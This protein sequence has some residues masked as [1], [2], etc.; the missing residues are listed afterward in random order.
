M[1][2]T[3]I[4]A[5]RFMIIRPNRIE[6]GAAMHV[7]SAIGDAFPLF[8]VVLILLLIVTVSYIKYEKLHPLAVIAFTISVISIFLALT[9]IGAQNHLAGMGSSARASLGYGFW[10]LLAGFILILVEH[11][12]LYV[13][14][15]GQSNRLPKH[16]IKSLVLLLCMTMLIVLYALGLLSGISIVRELTDKSDRIFG[17]LIRHMQLTIGATGTGLFISLFLSYIAYRKPVVERYVNMIANFAQVVPT[18]ALLGF[19]MIPLSILS[20]RYVF[21]KEIGISGIGFFPAYIVLTLYTLLPITTNTLAGFKT[22]STSVL[23][24]AQGM[25]MNRRQML[26]KIELP[27]AFPAIYT[28]TKTALIQAVG[29]CIL[30]GLVGGG[31]LGAILFLGLAQSA[32]DLV[33]VASLTVVLIAVFLDIVL[34]GF[35]GIIN[36]R[37]REEIEYD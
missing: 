19:I 14:K 28:G 10:M 6:S 29:N 18:L 2:F 36:K 16:L 22:I 21:L 34:T 37:F 35:E 26:L 15:A 33:I 4:A 7:G 31:G 25:G 11:T 9:G 30:A 27:M 20:S 24:A 32:F 3:G 12:N 13:Q 1:V 8:V 23:E 5:G 17:E